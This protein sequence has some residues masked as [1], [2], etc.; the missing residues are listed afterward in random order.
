MV[1]FTFLIAFSMAIGKDDWAVVARM[2]EL[3]RRQLEWKAHVAAISNPDPT[4]CA[5][6]F[7]S[8]APHF[9]SDVNRIEELATELPAGITI[10]PK[11]KEWFRASREARNNAI[12]SS[13][14]EGVAALQSA[15]KSESKAV[16]SAAIHFAAS[17]NV[18]FEGDAW[19][20]PFCLHTFHDI[21]MTRLKLDEAVDDNLS[22]VLPFLQDPDPVVVANI[23]DDLQGSH[24][25]LLLQKARVWATSPKP[26][27]RSLALYLISDLTNDKEAAALPFANDASQDIRRQ[28]REILGWP[29][30]ITP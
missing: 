16:R 4:L 25:K 18:F 29:E 10:S 6:A 24:D 9:E 17:Y 7:N 14:A 15:Y 23:A 26:R 30:N 2:H 11:T 27:L 20:T 8:W 19:T 28:A 22:L 13:R 21:F 5:E 3:D 1:A 12:R